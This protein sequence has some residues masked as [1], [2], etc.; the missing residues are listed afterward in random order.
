MRKTAKKILALVSGAVLLVTASIFG[1]MAYLVDDES[2]VN[3]FTV[4]KVI[5]SMD[6]AKTDE[7][8]KTITPEVRV[9]ENQYKL[10]PAVTYDK[11]PTIH[12]DPSSEECYLFVKIENELSEILVK[13]GEK[14]IAYQLETNGW[15]PIAGIDNMYFYGEKV[16]D[17]S[18]NTSISK[19]IANENGGTAHITVFDTFTVD[20]TVVASILNTYAPNGNE[21]K[22]IQITGYAIQAAGL[23]DLSVAQ[24]WGKF[25]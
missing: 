1:T 11:D 9:Q 12:I 8:G 6:E 15:Y 21:Y 23:S 10:V 19:K 22:K 5:I 14:S 18:G 2:V 20:E 4:G 25:N 7:Y 24:I 16:T 13:N 3:T 17:P